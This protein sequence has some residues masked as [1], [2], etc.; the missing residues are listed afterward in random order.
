MDLVTFH[1]YVDQ[2]HAAENEKLIN[3]GFIAMKNPYLFYCKGKKTIS[4]INL[5]FDR[6]IRFINEIIECVEIRTSTISNAGNG[7]FATCNISKNVAISIYPSDVTIIDEHGIIRDDSLIDR[8]HEFKALVDQ[9]AATFESYI[10]SFSP[11]S[12]NK[13]GGPS[14]TSPK[15][16]ALPD[17]RYHFGI[18]HIA[19]DAFP[20][21]NAIKEIPNNCDASTLELFCRLYQRYIDF[22]YEEANAVISE[23]KGI[24]YLK[25]IKE[26]SSND[27]I[28]T[29][30]GF[31][32]WVSSEMGDSIYSH[33]EELTFGLL[34]EK[35]P[36]FLDK[37]NFVMDKD[38]SYG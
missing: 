14:Y 29:T 4:L 11:N 22:A 38:Y 9:K 17:S 32:Y 37:F 7:L 5:I 8:V 16:L 24:V 34:L 20:D 35:D 13:T 18:G 36:T 10:Y 3:S 27:E 12:E 28:F 30:Y 19:N 2:I 33:L 6:I 1:T 15:I 26:I 31:K 21:T 25:S 23:Y